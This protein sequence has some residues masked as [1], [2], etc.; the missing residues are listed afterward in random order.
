MP[1]STLLI[2]E[3]FKTV[4]DQEVSGR[5]QSRKLQRLHRRVLEALEVLLR[6]NGSFSTIQLEHDVPRRQNVVC[7]NLCGNLV[8]MAAFQD[9]KGCVHELKS[10]PRQDDGSSGA[11]LSK[12]FERCTGESSSYIKYSIRPALY[13]QIASHRQKNWKTT[14][15]SG[16]LG[17]QLAVESKLLSPAKP[18]EAL[19]VGVGHQ[20]RALKA[21]GL[22]KKAMALERKYRVLLKT[23][24]C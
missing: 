16:K 1:S 18:K 11:S 15:L 6:E 7:D 17:D 9:W 8:S 14:R 20:I 21:L 12:L 3:D 19:A 22:G 4:I 13:A 23:S 24:N 10:I 2:R 5:S